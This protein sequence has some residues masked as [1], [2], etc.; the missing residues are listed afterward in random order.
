MPLNEKTTRGKGVEVPQE[1]FEAVE[2][3]TSVSG[4]KTKDVVGRVLMWVATQN[5][6]AQ[7]MIIN[8]MDDA[9]RDEYA[10]MLMAQRQDDA[11]DTDEEPA[12]TLKVPATARNYRRRAAKPETN[13]NG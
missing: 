4:R 1:A 12:P 5:P 11:E 3:L 6:T 7:K 8:H 10:M 9:M 2:V 13:K